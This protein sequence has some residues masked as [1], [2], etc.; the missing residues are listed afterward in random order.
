MGADAEPVPWPNIRQSSRSPVGEVEEGS[1]EPERLG[2]LLEH[3]LQ[4][5]LMGLTGALRDQGACTG[6]TWVL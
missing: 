5:Q 2:T 1:E 4:N 6:L 3:G